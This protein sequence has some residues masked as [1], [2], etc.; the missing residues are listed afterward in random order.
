MENILKYGEI[1]A[2]VMRPSLSPRGFGFSSNYLFS[3]P[4]SQGISFIAALTLSFKKR[5]NYLFFTPFILF[6]IGVNARIG[7]S[8]ILIFLVII[9][10]IFFSEI[11]VLRFK[12]KIFLSILILVLI[13]FL[14]Y[15]ISFIILKLPLLDKIIEWNYKGYLNFLD[16]I[17]GKD[18]SG[19]LNILL[20]YHI[21]F[22]KGLFGMLFGEAKYIFGSN[23]TIYHSDI[24]YVAL[25]FYGGIFY[26]LLKYGSF[27]LLFFKSISLKKKEKYVVIFLL[28]IF[29]GMM[30][31]QFKGNIFSSN[32]AFRLVFFIF[33]FTLVEMK[34][35]PGFKNKKNY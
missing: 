3:F 17:F 22:P 5:Y 27:A 10:F 32:P 34:L 24:G 18:L 15:K 16:I 20:K 33:I 13:T 11:L 30:V 29:V 1:N 31:A 9:F 26:S 6:S 35:K 21:F 28:S 8:I 25:L 23:S 2:K 12:K 19:T 4:I 14:S 7:Y